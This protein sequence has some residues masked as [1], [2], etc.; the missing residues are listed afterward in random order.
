MST[1]IKVRGYTR[2]DVLLQAGAQ[3]FVPP[4]PPPAHVLPFDVAPLDFARDRQD[5]PVMCVQG[6]VGQQKWPALSR[7]E[8]AC[9]EIA[10]GFPPVTRGQEQ[11]GH[12]QDGVLPFRHT[13]RHPPDVDQRQRPG[14]IA[15]DRFHSWPPI[16]VR[17]P[18]AVPTP[19]PLPPACARDLPVRPGSRPG[20]STLLGTGPAALPRPDEWPQWGDAYQA[21]MVQ[22]AGCVEPRGPAFRRTQ[23]VAIRQVIQPVG[24]SQPTHQ[25]F[26]PLRRRRNG[27]Q[28]QFGLLHSRGRPA[29]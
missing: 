9:P 5:R 20:P 16:T 22:R 11:W 2:D 1:P 21:Q 7:V 10:E 24:R 13:H 15:P 25:R 29:D 19:G 12:V 3:R 4:A 18:R 14:R 28:P 27:P 6:Q 17:I 23:G 26:R 8:G